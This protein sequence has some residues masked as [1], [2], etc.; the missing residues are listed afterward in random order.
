MN[1]QINNLIMYF[2]SGPQNPPTAYFCI[3]I[4]SIC[5]RGFTSAPAVADVL[6]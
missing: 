4:G 5:G 6:T 1:P 2:F 3:N